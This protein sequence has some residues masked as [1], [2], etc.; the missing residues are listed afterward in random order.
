LNKTTDGEARAIKHAA[1]E[2]DSAGAGAKETDVANKSSFKEISVDA[3]ENGTPKAYEGIE[4]KVTGKKNSP[5]E[6]A[7]EIGTSKAS[8]GDGGKGT[9]TNLSASK[10]S[11]KDW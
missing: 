9:G 6:E 3:M 11:S 5:G 8:D 2:D 7:M 1:K 4:G 10:S